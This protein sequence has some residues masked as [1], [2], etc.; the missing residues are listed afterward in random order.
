MSN[1]ANL[2]TK[3]EQACFASFHLVLF[4]ASCVQSASLHIY[5]DWALAP[6]SVSIKDAVKM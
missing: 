4:E 1:Y 6:L 5:L 2:P 3:E